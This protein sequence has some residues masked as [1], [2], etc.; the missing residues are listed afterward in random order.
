MK[1]ETRTIRPNDMNRVIWA[2]FPRRT[3]LCIHPYLH[4]IIEP[5]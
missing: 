2:R 5:I 3:L 4:I 1:K